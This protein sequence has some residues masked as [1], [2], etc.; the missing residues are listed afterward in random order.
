MFQISFRG[1]VRT[2]KVYNPKSVC[3]KH[4]LHIPGRETRVCC[5]KNLGPDIQS[6]VTRR[7]EDI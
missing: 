3:L 1:L 6:D 4:R 2:L 7:L 5:E